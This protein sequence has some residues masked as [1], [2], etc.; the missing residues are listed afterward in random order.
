MTRSNLNIHLKWLLDQGPS[1]YPVLTPPAWE[2]HVN[3]NNSYS[4]TAP[5]LSLVAS[6]PEEFSITNSQSF[7]QTDIKNDAI[8]EI[9]LDSDPEMARLMLAPSSASKPRMLSQKK[10]SPGSTQKSPKARSPTKRE[11]TQ[12]PSRTKGV[13]GTPY[14]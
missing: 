3:P 12:T 9:E 5:T 14:T 13:K 2:S 11:V 10:E 1:L 7:L 6:Q 4:N 8:D